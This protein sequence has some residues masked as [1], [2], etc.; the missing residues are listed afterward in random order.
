MYVT[1]F[2]IHFHSAD[3]IRSEGLYR[4]NASQDEVNRVRCALEEFGDLV[5]LSLYDV[6]AVA[7]AIKLYLRLLP[8]P[9]IPFD[10]Y[11]HFISIFGLLRFLVPV[12][13]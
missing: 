9:L 4:K 7:S 2:L 12:L 13:K 10:A 11:A 3:A 1:Y 8:I 6:N 5:D